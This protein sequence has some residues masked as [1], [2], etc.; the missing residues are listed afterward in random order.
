MAAGGMPFLTPTRIREEPLKS[1][2]PLQ[3]KLNFRLRTQYCNVYCIY[4]TGCSVVGL[5]VFCT[6]ILNE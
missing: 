3:R 2:G 4:T 6:K 1:G 5:L